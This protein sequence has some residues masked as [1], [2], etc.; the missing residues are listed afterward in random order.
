MDHLLAV[1]EVDAAA[2]AVTAAGG[3]VMTDP[4]DAVDTARIA[5]VLDPTGAAIGLWQPPDG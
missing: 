5:V 2:E 1:D 4:F 3:T